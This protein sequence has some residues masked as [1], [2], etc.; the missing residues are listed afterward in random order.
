MASRGKKK[1]QTRSAAAPAPV[2]VVR[3]VSDNRWTYVVAAMLVLLTVFLFVNS[4]TVQATIEYKDESGNNLLED[5]DPS[6]MTFGK[7]A[8]TT[9]FAPVNGYTDAID[10]TLMNMPLSKDSTIVQ[11]IA[12]QL[13]SSY[14]AQKLALLD[15]AYITIY[16][17]ETAY[18]A[19]SLA[20]IAFAIV[21]LVRK[22]EGDDVLSLAVAAVMTVLSAVRLIIGLVMC[23]N[24]TKEFTITAGGAPWLALVVCAAATVIL[25]VFVHGRKKAEKTE[26]AKR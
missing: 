22:K 16:V 26:E 8:I 18:L 12:K 15:T 3:K 14:P 7:S 21:V 2:A 23:L 13:V 4:F 9:I 17:T 11:D 20:F 6:Q 1:A 25:A 24:S 10:Y 5:I 19:L